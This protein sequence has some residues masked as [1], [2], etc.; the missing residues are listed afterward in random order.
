MLPP[1]GPSAQTL[2]RFHVCAREAAGA[3]C[4]GDRA[5][6][7]EP[8][9]MLLMNGTAVDGAEGEDFLQEV[10][11]RNQWR[12]APTEVGARPR[13]TTRS[14]S[15]EKTMQ[16]SAFKTDVKLKISRETLRVLETPRL[17]AAAGNVDASATV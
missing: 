10:A 1:R 3:A 5:A 16:K 7:L 17:V 12:E 9:S 14:A 15:K 13:W 2:F 4:A 11:A 6:W 8:V